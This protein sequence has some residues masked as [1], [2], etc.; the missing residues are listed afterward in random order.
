MVE[1]QIITTPAGEEL[2]VMPKAEFDALLERL[3]D[4]AEDA[5]DAVIYDERMAELKE[6]DLLSPEASIAALRGAGG[7]P[8]E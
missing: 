1:Y 5:A 4:A 6:G 3:A 7:R 8:R 2:V